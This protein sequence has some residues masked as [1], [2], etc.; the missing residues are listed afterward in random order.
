MLKLVSAAGLL[1]RFLNYFFL[2]VV[3][4]VVDGLAHVAV[5]KDIF[6]IIFMAG[7]MCMH[8]TFFFLCICRVVMV[9]VAFYEMGI[10]LPKR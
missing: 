2:T 6:L 9:A 7:P 5:V 3:S 8:L 4:S 10:K 1:T